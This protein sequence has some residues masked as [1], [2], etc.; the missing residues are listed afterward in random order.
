MAAHTRTERPGLRQNASNALCAP[1]DPLTGDWRLLRHPLHVGRLRSRTFDA[2]TIHAM[3]HP[4]LKPRWIAGH[5]LAITAVVVFVVLGLWQLRRH[6]ERV[7]LRERVEA[8]IAADP[9]PIEQVPEDGF[10]RVEVA[11]MFDPEAEF[12]VPRSRD[13][14]SGYELIGTLWLDSGSAVLVDR[15]WLGLDE[16]VPPPPPRVAGEGVLWPG[17]PGSR[18]ERVGE[19][20]PRIDP[21]A[22]SAVSP[23]DVRPEYLILTSQEPDFDAAIQPPEVGEVSLGPHLGY[24]GQWFLF[25]AVVLVG[26]PILLRRTAVSGQRSPVSQREE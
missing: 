17:E 15:G 25:A 5:L 3:A 6:D 11:G 12:R 22:V 20:L 26:Y 8:A 10:H 2:R 1:H 13:G 21:E 19:F 23:Y 9:V 14:M 24:A 4:L 16:P 18:F 7:E